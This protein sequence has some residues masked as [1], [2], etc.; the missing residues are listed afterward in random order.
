MFKVI[1][2]FKNKYGFHKKKRLLRKEFDY[3]SNQIEI[4]TPRL[5]LNWDE[6]MP[7]YWDKTIDTQYDHHYLLH[8]A[9]AMRK[10]KEINP[11]FHT[12]ISSSLNFCANLSAFIPVKFYDYRPANLSLSDLTSEHADLIKLHFDS[13]SINSLSCMHTIE[14][15][16]LGRYG[17]PLDYDGDIKAISELK[18]VVAIGGSLLFVVPVGKPKIVFNAHRIYS[19]KHILS[20]FDNWEL[21]EFSLITDDDKG[22]ALIINADE[23]MANNQNYGCG[24]FW[25]IKK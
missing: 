13:S 25:F 24:C 11:I 22:G 8:V 9:W 4:A 21:K 7:C 19:Y 1:G 23:E 14:H 18:R 20:F 15:I 16:G 2:Y 12:D 10:V 3:L 5:K 6:I 17:D